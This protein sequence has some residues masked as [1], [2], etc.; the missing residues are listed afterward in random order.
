MS[1][2]NIP[3]PITELITNLSVIALIDKEQKLNVNTKSFSSSNTWGASF[4]R[5]YQGESRNG[6]IIFLKAVLS[7]TILAIKDY[8]STEFLKIVVNHLK[9]ARPGIQNLCVTYA[10]DPNVLSQLQVIMENIDIQLYKNREL[11]DPSFE[12]III[13]KDNVEYTSEPITL[14]MNQEL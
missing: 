1:T 2:L 5:R 12:S 8:S 6:L 10:D 4:Y 9:L 11:I 3:G 14:F 7:E 13:N